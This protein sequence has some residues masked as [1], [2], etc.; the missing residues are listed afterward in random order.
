METAVLDA[1]RAVFAAR[2]VDGASVDAVAAA[3]G[4]TKGAVYS[5]FPSKEALFV[6]AALGHD[7]E[8]LAGIAGKTTA[9]W[10]RSWARGLAAQRQWA[11]LGMEF[12]L[13]GLRNRGAADTTREWQR[14]S[15]ARLRREMSRLLESSGLRLRVDADAAA[16]IV[17]AVAAGLA[18]QHYTDDAVDA[19]KLMKSVLDLLT[20]SR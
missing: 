13:F 11:L 7:D 4:L 19:E 18:Q 1:A 2:G 5:R 9:A 20:E 6:A 8:V 16:A 12:R 10:A 14:A 15:H 3:A 17:A